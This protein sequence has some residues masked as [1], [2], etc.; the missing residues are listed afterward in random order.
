M[1]RRM[2]EED[3]T[4]ALLTRLEE[5]GWTIVCYDFPQ[6]GTGVMIH[7]NTRNSKNKDSFIPDIVAHKEGTVLFFENKDRFVYS[8]FVKVEFLRTT[9]DYSSD[10]T[11]LLDGIEYSRILYGV[12][13]PY[14]V[15]AIRNTKVNLEMVDFAVLI[16]N[17]NFIQVQ[18]S[19]LDF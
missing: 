4:K 8:D 7:H 9:N 15:N 19:L 18:K 2:K 1:E 6:S 10:I 3:V 12:G 17:G 14:S 5:K 13:M 16:D 11:E